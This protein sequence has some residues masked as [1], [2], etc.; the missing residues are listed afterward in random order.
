MNS[1]TTMEKV[2][3]TIQKCEDKP[4]AKVSGYRAAIVDS[5][6]KKKEVFDKTAESALSKLAVNFLSHL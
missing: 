5:G 1:N 4:N 3:I 2:I 6:G